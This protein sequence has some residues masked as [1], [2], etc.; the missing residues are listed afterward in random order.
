VTRREAGDS[1]DP[2]LGGLEARLHP[3]EVATTLIVEGRKP[4][5]A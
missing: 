4:G 2:D 1:T 5:G 3:A